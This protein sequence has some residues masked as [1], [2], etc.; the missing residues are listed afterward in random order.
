VLPVVI[1]THPERPHWLEDCLNS[2]HRTTKRRVLIHE[3]GGYEIAALRTGFARFDRFLFLQD[4]VTILSPEFWLIVDARKGPA[5]LSGWPPMFLGIWDASGRAVIE[6]LPTTQTK[7][8]S[9]RLEADIPELLKWP[10][11]WPEVTD[12]TALRREIRHGRHNLVVGNRYW[13]KAK[14]TFR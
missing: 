2:I 3:A 1:G 12:H 11:I 6:T 9:I 7:E 4:S 14:A 8:D 13:E 5:W 10:T